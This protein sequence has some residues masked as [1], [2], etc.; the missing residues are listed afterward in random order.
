MILIEQ[1][2]FEKDTCDFLIS[3][4]LKN[5]SKA[6]PFRDIY[7]LPF[8]E[9]EYIFGKKIINYVTNF[10]GRR[11]LISY[12]ERMQITIWNE[13][14][15]QDM[16]FDTAKESTNLTSITYLNSD[17]E[18]GETVFKNGISIR[19]EKGKTVFF[20]GK[21]YFHGVNPVKKGKRLILAIWYTS[22]I[23]S[24]IIK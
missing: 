7:V 21:K 17:Y 18:G 15:K 12:P 4:A 8:L 3:L 16:H 20:D 5:E 14:S 2:F 19:P 10:L 1:D 13:N 9:I 24:I 11:G 6:N 22:D 23:N